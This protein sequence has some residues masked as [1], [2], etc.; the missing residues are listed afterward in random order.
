MEVAANK[1]LHYA[2]VQHQLLLKKNATYTLLHSQGTCLRP[3]VFP[4]IYLSFSKTNNKFPRPLKT[5]VYFTVFQKELNHT[6][7][8]I[9]CCIVFRLRKKLKE[10]SVYID[11]C[12]RLLCDINIFQRNDKSKENDN[13]QL[14]EHF[15]FFFQQ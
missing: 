3:T 4:N 7:S 13:T 14:E 5:A 8:H 15:F 6:C 11:S 2:D 12:Y 1:L 9:F 10:L